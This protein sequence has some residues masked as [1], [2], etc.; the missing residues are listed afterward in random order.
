MKIISVTTE[1]DFKLK[2]SFD[3]GLSGTFDVKPYLQYEAFEAL[4]EPEAFTK[5]FNGK[6]YIEWDCGADLSIDTIEAH[7]VAI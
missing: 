2:V 6:Y 4:K 1:N 7:L 5:I 3:T